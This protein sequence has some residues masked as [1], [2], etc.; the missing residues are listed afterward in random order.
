MSISMSATAIPL[1]PPHAALKGRIACPLCH[2][3]LAM[4]GDRITCTACGSA[5]RNVDGIL[6]LAPPMAMP[7]E[8]EEAWL[9]HWADGNQQSPAQRF[10][11]FYRKAVFARTVR[12]F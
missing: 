11:I 12:L 2:S 10:F 7:K 8:E 6:D 4:S 3:E 1:I 5:H 9:K